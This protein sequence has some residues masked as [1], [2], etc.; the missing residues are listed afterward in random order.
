[1]DGH[2][3]TSTVKK[4]GRRK[5]TGAG[6]AS[7][8]SDA[9][10]PN[11]FTIKKRE[12][13]LQRFRA[14]ASVSGG[15]IAKFFLSYEEILKRSSG[16]YSASFHFAPSQRVEQVLLNLMVKEMESLAFTKLVSVPG[17]S[18]ADQAIEAAA[19]K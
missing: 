19:G 17:N 11:Y 15:G 8:K 7:A 18:T 3:H 14:K 6:S 16:T 10:L 12:G 1:M 5:R 13:G 9:L 4:R 2:N